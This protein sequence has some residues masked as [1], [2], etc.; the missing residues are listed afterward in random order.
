MKVTAVGWSVRG[1][2]RVLGALAGAVVSMA[3]AGPVQAQPVAGTAVA[4][5]CS[6]AASD[7]NGDGVFDQA[8][9]D[10]EAS[11]DGVANAGVVR[12]VYGGGKGTVE[13]TQ[14]LS[15]VD[16]TPEQGDQFGFSRAVYDADGDGCSDVVVG[17]PYE[18]VLVDGVNRVDAGAVYVFHGSPSGIGTGAP[19]DAWTQRTLHPGTASEAYDRFGYALAA[20]TAASGD[21]WLAVGVP[22]ESVT[23]DDVAHTEA[24]QVEYKQGSAV[25]GVNQ[26]T[27]GVGGVV[28]AY[29]RMGMALAGTNRYFAAGSPGEAVGTEEFA[30]AVAVFS[31]TL[32]GSCPVALAGLG[33]GRA[34]DA[35]PD[36]AEAGDQFGASLSMTGYRPSNQTYNSDALLAIGVPGEAVGSVRSAGLVAVV[37]VQPSGAYTSVASIDTSSADVEGT[38][39]ASDFFGQR[40]TIAN[41]DTS[42]VTTSGTVRLAVSVPGRDVGDAKDAGAVQIFRPL[43]TSPGA[44]DK[45]LTRGGAGSLLPGPATAR[46]YTGMSLWSGSNTLYVGVPYSKEP[47]TSKG[48]LYTMP[49]SAVD[50]GSGTATTYRPGAGGL[51]DE[52][53]SFG[54]IH[55]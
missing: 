18:D 8:I 5:A 26:N 40:V 47:A 35:L 55:G 25:C 14:A 45:V 54:V 7:F 49:W 37:R 19:V 2:H 13:L 3:A 1:I 30:G 17:V 12:V 42:V 36:S 29:D 27:P 32:D 34:A 52:G 50:A 23:V 28:E 46:D 20:G 22:G 31:H 15:S 41:T 43:D 44:S 38:P 6:G 24:G 11:V 48:V 21:P 39:A 10:P 33:Q 16:A 53:A 51:P 4:A 9:G